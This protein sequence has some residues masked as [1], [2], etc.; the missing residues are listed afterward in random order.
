MRKARIPLPQSADEIGELDR[1]IIAHLVAG[2]ERRRIAA[3]LGFASAP[4]LSVRVHRL[5][6]ILPPGSIPAAA[7]REPHSRSPEYLTPL[8]RRILTLHKAGHLAPQIARELAIST[9]NVK[10]RIENLRQILPDGS[11]PAKKSYRKPVRRDAPDPCEVPAPQQRLQTDP[12][13]IVR[14]LGGCERQWKSPDRLRIRIC[15]SCKDKRRNSGTA[16]DEY[17]IIA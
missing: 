1:Q 11:L 13:G 7:P 4:A 14:C 12:S 15:Q 16:Y 9:F 17:R 5:R 10:H 8:D 3:L 2:T 6:A